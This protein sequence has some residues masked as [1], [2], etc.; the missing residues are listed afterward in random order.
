MSNLSKDSHSLAYRISAHIHQRSL[1]KPVQK[2][3]QPNENVPSD[4]EL[5]QIYN[6]FK[7]ADK[8]YSDKQQSN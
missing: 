1:Q 6:E 8:K 7:E 2:S 3:S 4:A 5:K